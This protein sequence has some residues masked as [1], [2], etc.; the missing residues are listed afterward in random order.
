[1]PSL[2][3]LLGPV[4]CLP[5]GAGLLTDLLKLFEKQILDA[6]SRNKSSHVVDMPFMSVEWTSLKYCTQK[7]RAGTAENKWS[8]WKWGWTGAQMRLL[9]V[10]EGKAPVSF[11]LCPGELF[12]LLDAWSGRGLWNPGG[13]RRGCW[14]CRWW[15]TRQPILSSS[16]ESP[17][18][19]W[20]AD[21][22]Y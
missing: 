4:H 13:C 20:Q 6:P 8:S 1:M 3:G 5:V 21:G 14:C 18:A 19:L 15:E 10:S 2:T 12:P 11:R 9:H 7:L 16:V 17:A 22:T